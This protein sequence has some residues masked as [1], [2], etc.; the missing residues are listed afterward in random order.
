MRRFKF[1]LLLAFL[2]VL[3]VFSWR[4]IETRKTHQINGQILPC[5][6]QDAFSYCSFLETA[7]GQKFLLTP[8]SEKKIDKDFGLEQ[9]YGR[10][11]LTRGNLLGEEIAVFDEGNLRR[12]SVF[13][14][15]VF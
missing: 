6:Y 4:E 13:E 11:V 8:E 12:F 10:K 3:A 15:K 1:L 9:I 7:G 5:Q 14:L 2:L